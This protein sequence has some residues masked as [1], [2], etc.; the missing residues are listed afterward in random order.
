MKGFIKELIL[1][2]FWLF[3]FVAFSS[4]NHKPSGG[5]NVTELKKQENI[6]NSEVING[7]TNLNT[8]LYKVRIYY[9]GF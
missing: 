4:S 1:P 2:S 9:S 6:S 5:K 3:F 7:I 8:Q